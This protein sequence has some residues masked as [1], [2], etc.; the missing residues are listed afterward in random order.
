LPCRSARKEA[1]QGK[2]LS[3]DHFSHG[4]DADKPFHPIAL[5]KTF[6]RLARGFLYLYF[7]AFS[8]LFSEAVS[9]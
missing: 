9:L 3:C 6:R 5:Q 4:S 7:V 8:M 2:I 1:K